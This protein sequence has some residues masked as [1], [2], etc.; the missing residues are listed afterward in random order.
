MRYRPIVS[1]LL[2]PALLA[3]CALISSCG[4]KNK[5]TNAV[6][7][8]E[9]FESG[10]LGTTAPTNTF[11]HLFG[12][13]GTFDFRCRHHGSMMGTVTV[14]AGGADSVIWPMGSNFFGTPNPGS[15]VK[16]GGYVRW[17]NGSG[18]HTVTRP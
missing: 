7:V 11:V 4:S 15:T 13:A 1:L 14:A 18:V 12:T 8:T 17:V 9:A 10:D 2:V 3:A 5:S 6:Q 16:I